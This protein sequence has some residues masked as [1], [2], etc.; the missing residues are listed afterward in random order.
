[1]SYDLYFFTSKENPITF[2]EIENYLS[3]NLVP[4]ENNQWF[5]HNPDSEVY[6]TFLKTE[7]DEENTES[8]QNLKDVGISFNLNFLRPSFF[9]IEAFKFVE[10][11]INDLDLYVFNPQSENEKPYKPTQK[12]LFDNWNST[13]LNASS[14]HFSDQNTYLEIEKSNQ[15][16]SYNVERNSIQQK[17]GNGYFVPKMFFFKTKQNN[18]VVTVSSWTEHIP[19]IIPPADYFLLTKVQKKWFRTKTENALISREKLLSTFGYYLDDYDFAG[20][21]IIHPENAQKIK[22]LFNNISSDLNLET[23]AERIQIESLFNSK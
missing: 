11:L 12:E 21:K 22:T 19:N 9:G 7:N 10:K 16:W 2:E 20:C 18:E 14:I 6:F 8:F 13:N 4:E 23:F 15:I 17:L 5:F 3:F 1:M